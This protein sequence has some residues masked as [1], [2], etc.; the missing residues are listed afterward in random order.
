MATLMLPSSLSRIGRRRS[1]T[2][3]TA[4]TGGSCSHVPTTDRDRL[5]GVG[6]R[7]PP[8]SASSR[9]SYFLMGAVCDVDRTPLD[10]AVA[11]VEKTGAHSRRR[12]A[13]SGVSW[14]TP[15]DAVAI[16][17]L[18][19][20]GTPSPRFE[21]SRGQGRVR[22]RPL[23]YSVAEGRM[24]ADASLSTSASPRWATTS[25]T[26]FRTTGVWWTRESRKLGRITRAPAGGWRRRRRW[27]VQTV[28]GQR[29]AAPTPTAP[30]RMLDYD[31]CLVRLRTAVSP[32]AVARIVQ[33]VVDYSGGT[34]S[35]LLGAHLDVT[36][37]AS[38][39]GP[40]WV[41]S[42]GGRFLRERRN[43][44]AGHVEAVREYPDLLV[45]SVCAPPLAGFEHLGRS[46]ALSG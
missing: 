5:I 28:A 19:I 17:T 31:F 43:R 13:T 27:C 16:V 29:G 18:P 30:L 25:T 44:D 10:R 41:T 12:S 8:P 23:S 14:K 36:T 22:L 26:T 11:E 24:M 34:F 20:T 33:A 46:V 4:L 9:A 2:A 3:M 35:R 21:P 32:A 40:P 37:W 7:A 6:G 15:I 45:C 38:I 42:V 1:L 39:S